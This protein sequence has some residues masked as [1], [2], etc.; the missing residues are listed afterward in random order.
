PDVEIGEQ[1][2]LDIEGGNGVRR[3]LGPNERGYRRISPTRTMPGVENNEAIAAGNSPI[4]HSSPY[5]IPRPEYGERRVF[6]GGPAH[7]IE[8]FPF[9]N[10]EDI[11]ATP[12]S[13]NV[14]PPTEIDDDNES[15]VENIDPVP[16]TELHPALREPRA[17][18][19]GFAIS[20][21]ISGPQELP[22]INPSTVP[23]I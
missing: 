23:D 14:Y 16:P 12:P 5:D 1:S 8:T 21:R 22:D 18:Q 15:Q 2:R 3:S 20:G 9:Q 6:R 4:I 11:Y 19:L 13:R 17:S 10:H 7:V